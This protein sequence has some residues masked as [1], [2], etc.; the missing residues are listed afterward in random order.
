MAAAHVA[1]VESARAAAQRVLWRRCSDDTG[2]GEPREGAEE[3]T[4]QWQGGS[5]AARV[6]REQD[7]GWPHLLLEHAHERDVVVAAS[8]AAELRHQQERRAGGAPADTRDARRRVGGE[9]LAVHHAVPHRLQEGGGAARPLGKARIA[10]RSD[11][12]APLCDGRGGQ[13][14]RCHQG[15]AA[16]LE[17]RVQGACGQVWQGGDR[18]RVLW[19]AHDRSGTQGAMRGAVIERGHALPLTQ[20]ELLRANRN[21]C[22]HRSA[23]S[24]PGVEVDC[25]VPSRIACMYDTS[26][27]QIRSLRLRGIVY[28]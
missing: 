10:R 24:C 28:C 14:V 5:L 2:D 27:P 4:W 3:R 17:G 8:G 22:A 1:T 25:F 9:P 7:G 6:V 18:R 16:R 20:R 15:G 26:R 19:R 21:P 12:R 13:A 23:A 11:H